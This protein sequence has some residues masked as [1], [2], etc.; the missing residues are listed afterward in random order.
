MTGIDDSW[1][2]CVRSTDA[3]HRSCSLQ[4]CVLLAH[5]I[6]RGCNSGGPSST[7]GGWQNDRFGLRPGGSVTGIQV[8]E[9]GKNVKL[10]KEKRQVTMDASRPAY[11]EARLGDADLCDM[12]GQRMN[13]H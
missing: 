11:W 8:V 7:E 2:L 9:E 10:E 6:D 3:V 1:A 5:D 12:Y 13:Q 4:D